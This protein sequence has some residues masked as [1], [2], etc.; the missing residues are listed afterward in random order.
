MG[1]FLWGEW[2]EPLLAWALFCMATCH[3][4]SF[5]ARFEKDQLKTEDTACRHAQ[6]VR[7]DEEWR[8]VLSRE[9][10]S[11]LRKVGPPSDAAE[12]AGA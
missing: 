11:V 2:A 1:R 3:G 9:A 5:E 6:V 8:R 10:Y 12:S 4:C 7:T